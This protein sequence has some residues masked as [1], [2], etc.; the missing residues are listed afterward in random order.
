IRVEIAF[1]EQPNG[2]PKGPLFDA[3]SDAIR[4]VHPDAVILPYLSTGFTD[5]RFF[6][7]IGVD[8]YGLMPV[9]LPREEFGRIHGVDERIP[10]AGIDEMIRI[11][12]ALI[13]GWNAA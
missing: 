9:L 1:A 6:R 3:L 10:L 4:S 13:E 7:S 12:S 5:S 8:T 2:S 11:V